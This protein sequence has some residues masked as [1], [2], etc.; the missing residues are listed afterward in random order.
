MR[1]LTIHSVPILISFTWLIVLHQTFNPVILKGPDFLKFYLILI[2]GFYAS[3]FL[4]KN[5]KET[6]SRTT[7]YFSGFILLLG[8]IK[9]VRG[10]ILGKPIGFLIIILLMEIV[11]IL[12]FM[13]DDVNKKIK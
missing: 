6:I 7:L 8:I 4:L 12:I 11:V 9:L 1:K 2:S 13:V 3:I 10:M 5:L